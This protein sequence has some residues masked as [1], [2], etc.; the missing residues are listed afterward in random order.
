[1]GKPRKIGDHNRFEI[2][3]DMKTMSRTEVCKKHGLD[4]AML[5]REFGKAWERGPAVAKEQEA[6]S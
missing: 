5:R 6:A 3:Q 2:E 4:F 1:M